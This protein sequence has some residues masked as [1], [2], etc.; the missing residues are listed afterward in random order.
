MERLLANPPVSRPTAPTTAR[1]PKQ[2]QARLSE[3]QTKALVADYLAGT[4]IAGVAGKYDVDHATALRRLKLAGVRMRSP[5]RAIPDTE[6]PHLRE[7]R[8]LGWSY[9]RIGDHYGS[10]VGRLCRTP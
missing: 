10:A 2:R 9:Q 8:A 6:L 4:S 5:H 7:L 3:N 1:A